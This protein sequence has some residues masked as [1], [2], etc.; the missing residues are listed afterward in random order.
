MSL[1]SAWYRYFFGEL[2]NNIGAFKNLKTSDVEQA[3]NGRQILCSLKTLIKFMLEQCKKH[4]TYFENPTEN[5]AN[6][7]FGY[8]APAL[9]WVSDQIAEL[10]NLHGPHMRSMYI[11]V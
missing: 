5:E 10:S 11:Q 8:A 2:L 7:M 3:K 9:F 1:Q 6:K 4:G